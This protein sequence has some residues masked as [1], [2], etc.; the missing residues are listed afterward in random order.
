MGLKS[1]SAS[2]IQ[3]NAIRTLGLDPG[4][5]DFSST[6][7]I[8]CCIRRVAGFLCPC[9]RNTLI[10]A[11]LEPLRCIIPDLESQRTAIDDT[12]EA[13]VAYG[14]LL[15]LPR[16]DQV[17]SA[18]SRLLVYL[19]PPAFVRRKSGRIM[20]FGVLPDDVSLLP[21]DIMNK[22]EYNNHIRSLPPGY[23]EE[24]IGQLTEL[25]Y[26][27]ISDSSWLKNPQ[28]ETTK[29]Y[30]IRINS[31]LDA[32]PTSGDVIG[33]KI[34]DTQRSVR[35]YR[36]RWVEPKSYSGRF[37]GRR[38]QA[39]GSDL[40]CFVELKS[41]LP[42]RLI[43]LPIGSDLWRGCDQAWILQSAIDYD[44]NNP[45]QFRIRTGSNETS[46]IDIFSPIPAWAKRRLD[47]IGEPAIPSGC[48]FTYR[49]D[50]KEK[51]EEIQFLKEYLW[52]AKG[53]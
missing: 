50:N 33:L 52:L 53:D 10:Y 2:T 38:A 29:Q 40:W 35:Y 15:E 27:E 48:L 41:G 18:T 11:I 42:T 26:V 45:Q 49:I 32:A 22:M 46:L 19:A 44:N 8:A 14:D 13:L 43:D 23:D 25:G 16:T 37:V 12:I 5:V 24:H 21:Q 9:S 30:L 7:T 34:L 36:D 28:K 1:L 4:A 17:G 3:E 20:I 47:A 39:Y 6:E 51:K 31:L